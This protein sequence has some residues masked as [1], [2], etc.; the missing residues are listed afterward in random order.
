MSRRRFLIGSG[1]GVAAV[2]GSATFVAAGPDR[3]LRHLGLRDS[4]DRRVP[5]SGRPVVDHTLRSAAMGREVTYAIAEPATR[6][7]G[8][9]ICLHGRGSDHRM[10]FDSVFLHDVVADMGVALA[11]VGVD[12]GPATYWHPRADGTDAMA[13]VL[14]E[15][16]PTIDDAIGPVPRALLGWSMGGYGSLLLAE[17][18]P[19]RFV[20][21]AAASPAI[22]ADFGAATEGAFDGEAD[23]AAHDIFGGVDSLA[24][25]DVRVDC[26]TGDRFF[27]QSRRFAASLPRPNLG[28]FGAGHHDDPYWRSIAPDQIR[29]IMDAVARA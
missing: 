15:L 29:T 13:L 3:V 21:V 19:D 9:V 7:V 27:E 6:A 12:G 11:V 22:F 8:V 5:A 2:V 26:G 16:L 14:D 4:P 28:G 17:R 23:F 18:A 1:A 10:A 25:L 24:A 20:A